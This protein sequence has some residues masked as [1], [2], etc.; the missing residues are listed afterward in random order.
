MSLYQTI[1]KELP[2]LGVGNVINLISVWL[3]GRPGWWYDSWEIKTSAQEQRFKRFLDGIDGIK[4][5]FPNDEGMMKVEG[6]LVYNE[7]LVKPSLLNKYKMS[8]DSETFG[9]IIGYACAKS[10]LGEDDDSGV[11]V[12]FDLY[13][14]DLGKVLFKGVQ[15]FGQACSPSF[16]RGVGSSKLINQVFHLQKLFTTHHSE[17]FGEDSPLFI[18]FSINFE[19]EIPP[20]R[21]ITYVGSKPPS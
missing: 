8:G 15:L 20:H 16:F 12:N 11:S 17:I 3:G 21:L 7:A 10:T 6:P 18:D 4:Y 5:Y 14:D 1:R 19:D 13:D 2:F 9:K